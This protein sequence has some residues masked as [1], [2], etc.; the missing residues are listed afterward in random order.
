MCGICGFVSRNRIDEGTLQAM[1]GELRHRGPDDEGFYESHLIHLGHRRLSIIDLEG[2]HQPI[3]N[4]DNSLVLVFNGEIYNFQTLRR[5]L[6][7]R[8][9]RFTTKG[10]SEVL[11]HHQEELRECSIS[12]AV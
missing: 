3:F 2:S 7:T 1:T 6:L 8:G 10:D 9:H 12:S 4:E 5:E 11:V